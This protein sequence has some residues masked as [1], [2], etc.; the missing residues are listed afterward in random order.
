M[1]LED[2]AD[3]LRADPGDRVFAQSG[4]IDPIDDDAPLRGCIEGAE[5]VEQGAFPAARG[6]NDGEALTRAH[7][8][9]ETVEDAAFGGAFVPFGDAAQFQ[10]RIRLF[11]HC[12]KFRRS[13]GLLQVGNDVS[14]KGYRSV[15]RPSAHDF[16]SVAASATI[17]HSAINSFT[18]ASIALDQ[19]S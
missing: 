19:I 2:E 11:R 15:E 9:I 10:D 13:R 18:L 6:T 7:D 8:E 12:P 3:L 1:H 16:G 5:E 14:G 4:R 17:D